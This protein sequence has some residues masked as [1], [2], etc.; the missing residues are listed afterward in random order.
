MRD[1]PAIFFPNLHKRCE[2]A[3]NDPLLERF[4]QVSKFLIPPFSAKFHPSMQKP[5][6]FQLNYLVNDKDHRTDATPRFEQRQQSSN[7]SKIRAQNTAF[8]PFL[9]RTTCI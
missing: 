5:S 2:T 1:V 4:S 8:C 7:T 3:R 6:A 9:Y